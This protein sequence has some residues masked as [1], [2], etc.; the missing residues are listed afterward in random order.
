MITYLWPAASSERPGR[1]FADHATGPCTCGSRWIGSA[2]LAPQG[3]TIQDTTTIWLLGGA[4]SGKALW[5]NNKN[6][7]AQNNHR[8]YVLPTLGR[9]PSKGARSREVVLPAPLNVPV[10]RAVWSPFDGIW[11]LLK[12]SWGVL[13]VERVQEAAWTVAAKRDKASRSMGPD[14]YH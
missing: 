10:F 7:K 4:R 9:W 6:P 12:G 5:G 1:I 13:V 2:T 14:T 11:G 3:P 8:P